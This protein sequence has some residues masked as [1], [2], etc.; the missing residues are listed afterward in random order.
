MLLCECIFAID[1]SVLLLVSLLLASCLPFSSTVFLG[2]QTLLA[3]PSASEI[4][5]FQCLLLFL[6]VSD[7]SGVKV[8]APHAAANHAAVSSADRHV[9]KM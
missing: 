5:S 4:L 6:F 2:L 7:S 1:L 9:E 3:E 8:S